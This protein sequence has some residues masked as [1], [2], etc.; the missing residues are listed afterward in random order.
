V[1]VVPGIRERITGK[2]TRYGNLELPLVV[3][4]NAAGSDARL[5]HVEEALFG[6]EKWGLTRD[7]EPIAG[8]ANDGVW[9]GPKG[10]RCRAL[11]AVLAVERLD[12]WS[13]AQRHAK[14]GLRGRSVTLAGY[15]DPHG[16]SGTFPARGA[17]IVGALAG[18]I[19]LRALWTYPRAKS[20]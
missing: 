15:V 14:S 13:L 19:A 4:V 10:P 17:R 5:S 16:N 1:S 6:T 20:T 3:A 12:P 18:A 8:R 11:S 9:K 2:A 7:G